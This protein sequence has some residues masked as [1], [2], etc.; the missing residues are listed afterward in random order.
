[1]KL[2]AAQLLV[3]PREQTV[4]LWPKGAIAHLELAFAGLEGKQS[5]HFLAGP[6]EPG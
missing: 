6:I 2:M 4:P 1:M 3:L 5:C